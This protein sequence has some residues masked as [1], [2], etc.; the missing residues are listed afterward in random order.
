MQG[1]GRA[2]IRFVWFG[3]GVRIYPLLADAVLAVRPQLLPEG[4]RRGPVAMAEEAENQAPADA[5]RR[6]SALDKLKKAS[7]LAAIVS[8]VASSVHKAG[9]AAVGG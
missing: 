7:H 4:T 8:T 3:N 1:S 5:E 9:P 2:R 6:P